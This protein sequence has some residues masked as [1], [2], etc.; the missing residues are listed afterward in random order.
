[1]DEATLL[2]HGVNSADTHVDFMIGTP[3]MAL[4]GRCADGREITLMVDGKFAAEVL[5]GA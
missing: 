5:Q 2:A 1:M 3:T 4:Y